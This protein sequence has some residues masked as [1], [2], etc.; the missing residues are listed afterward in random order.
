MTATDTPLPRVTELGLTECEELVASI[1]EK[2]FRAKQL[3]EWIAGKGV[4]DPEQ[5]TNL[6]ARLRDAL[7]ERYRCETPGFRW[8]V[9]EGSTTEK[10]F[11]PLGED[12]DGVEA[13][14]IMEGDRT[15]ACISSQVGCPVGC[16]FC[17]SGLLGLVRNLTRG[18]IIEQFLEVRRRSNELGRRLSNIVMMGMGEPLLNYNAVV[19]ALEIFN[20]PKG[21][22]I[23]ARHLT[24]STIGMSKGIERLKQEGKQFTLA[25]SLHAPDDETRQDLIPFAGALGVDGLVDAARSYLDDTGREVTFEY[26]MLDGVNASV[27]HA[28]K[29]AGLLK[30]VRGTVNLIPYNENPGLEFRRPSDPTVDR[31]VDVLRAAGV[32]TSVRKRKGNKILAACGQLRLQETGK[33]K[34]P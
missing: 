12:G 2:P 26:V 13:V 17:A 25:F 9:D 3:F 27:E 15:T 19:G 33:G 20:H 30:G 21:G 29:L 34:A 22:G 32:K 23:G 10:L 7:R 11:L 14:L 16:K 28:R 6:P 18:E 5:M 1:G 4:R 24:V 31:F 8:S